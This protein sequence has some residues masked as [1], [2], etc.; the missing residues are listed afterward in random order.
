MNTT[1]DSRSPA[2]NARSGESVELP[3]A[4][5]DWFKGRGWT[6]RPHQLKLLSNARSGRS[7][8]LLAPTGAGK[9]LAGFLPSLIALAE[10][11]PGAADGTIDTLYISPPKALAVDIARNLEAPVDGM[12]LNVRLETRT[13]DTPQHKRRQQ[14]Y[15][16]PQILLT[17]PEQLALMLASAEASPI[18]AGLKAIFL[19]ELHSLVTSKRGDLLALGISRLR[20]LSPDPVTI[21]LSATVA[22]P[23]ELRA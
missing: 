22:Q 10:A 5:R 21:G 4:F 6:P 2:R 18:F 14:K 3:P 17:T 12:G 13:G 9:T 1:A 16:P 23:D 19:D 8:L 15:D 20:T 11:G 7:T